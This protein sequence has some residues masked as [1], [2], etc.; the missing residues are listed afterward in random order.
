[1]DRSAIEAA[2]D[3]IA[4]MRLRR[5]G[6]TPP[7]AALPEAIRP[8]T[9]ADGYRVQAA[10]R[11][12]LLPA[13][14][15]VAGWKVG[16][17]S[18][19]MQA[20]LKIAYPCAGALYAHRVWSGSTHVS[21]ADFAQLGLECEVAVRLKARLPAH[22]PADL[23]SVLAL[24]ES[25]HASIEI[26]EW[27]WRDWQDIG[28]PTLIADDFFS[29]G[30]VTGSPADPAILAGDA[31][32]AGRF[33]VDG[34]DQAAAPASNILG[35]PLNALGWLVGHLAAQGTPLAGG[36][37]VTLGAIAS[38]FMVAGPCHVVARFDGLPD[39]AVSLR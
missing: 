37:M 6:E 30:C 21:R 39:V 19:A 28:A 13:F 14:G 7:I 10:V 3:R 35:H 27:R 15:P 29:V 17:T 25:V 12:R 31:G 5:P 18:P 4:A 11:S 26:V 33:V 20:Y 36:A 23:P 38:P 32:F 22:D 1:M 8:M 9:V 2:A 24:V 34:V 16:S